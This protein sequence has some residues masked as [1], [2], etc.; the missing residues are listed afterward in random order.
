MESS[1]VDLWFN[2][3][4]SA[5]LSALKRV[6]AG[7]RFNVMLAAAIDSYNRLGNVDK[8]AASAR[9][10]VSSRTIQRWIRDGIP[11]KRLS[12]VVS[13][14]RPPQGAFVQEK[15]DLIN[16]WNAVD[17]IARNRE[18]AHD[19]WG[20]RGWLEPHDLAIV[21]LADA[22]VRTV[23]IANS[24]RATRLLRRLKAGH[25]LNGEEKRA[26]RE[27]SAGGQIIDIL[28]FPNRFSASIARGEILNDVYA[29]RINL[30][31]GKIKRGGSK[32]WLSEGPHKKLSSYRRRPR[33]LESG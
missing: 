18:G 3:E 27:L 28:T 13:V 17:V 8:S 6:W 11:D 29:Y 2:P 23:R 26:I 30:P 10:G 31:E 21:E 20:D 15:N 4:S 5:D 19:L 22:P 12:D 14:V 25:N 32:A 7:E 9:L 33:P 1:G 16:D 24:S